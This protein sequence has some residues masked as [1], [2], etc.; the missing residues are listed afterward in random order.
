M[1]IDSKIL[2]SM[3]GSLP[4]HLHSNSTSSFGY[5]YPPTNRVLST[6][7]RLLRPS[8][9]RARAREPEKGFHSHR[10]T[11]TQ[12]CWGRVE[13][14]CVGPS[15]PDEKM[16]VLPLEADVSAAKNKH[17]H[18]DNNRSCQRDNDKTSVIPIP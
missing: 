17:E 10:D 16:T 6:C 4:D 5:S 15:S 1:N 12:S 14:V 8:C 7:F 2:P 11:K 18:N 9:M 3:I 13:P